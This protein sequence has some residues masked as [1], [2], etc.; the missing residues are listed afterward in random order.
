MTM[1]SIVPILL[2][3]FFTCTTMTAQKATAEAIVQANLDAYNTGD[4]DGFMSYF[5]SEIEMVNFADGTQTAKGL[6][7]VRDIYEPYFKASPDLHSTILQRVVIGNKVIDHESITG[8]YGSDDVLKLVLI[9][10]V[11]EGKITKIT[12]IRE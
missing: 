5:S 10:E 8:R 12:V 9:Y 7:A 2:C 1:K 6:T 11:E 4:I 3:L